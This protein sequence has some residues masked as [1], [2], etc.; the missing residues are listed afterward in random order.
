M[1]D[2]VAYAGVVLFPTFVFAVFAYCKCKEENQ[3]VETAHRPRP[4]SASPHPA[5]PPVESGIAQV[6]LDSYQRRRA[7][8]QIL[9]CTDVEE[10]ANM[11][12]QESV[13]LTADFGDNQMIP[14]D[15]ISCSI[16]LI[17]Y[18]HGDTI[19]RNAFNESS[20]SCN[21]IFHPECIATWIE[22]SR[23]TEC[24]C[25]RSPFG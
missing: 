14:V 7:M 12:S 9:E 1:R 15:E 16:C 21:H 17:D 3:E 5:P 23:K 22:R 8:G 25:C 6:I 11:E 10:Q 24:P 4:P 13:I 19:Q 2:R 18:Q 20:I